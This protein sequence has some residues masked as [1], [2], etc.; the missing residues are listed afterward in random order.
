MSRA[1]STFGQCEFSKI[2]IIGGIRHF[3]G[4]IGLNMFISVYKHSH[5]EKAPKSGVEGGLEVEVERNAN[6]WGKMPQK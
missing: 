2:S 3:H 4:F 1:G 6:D 5:I